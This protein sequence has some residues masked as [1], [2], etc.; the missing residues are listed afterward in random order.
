MCPEPNFNDAART[1]YWRDTH[2]FVSHYRWPVGIGG[3]VLIGLI[4]AGWLMRRN[5][6]LAK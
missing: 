1:R 3:L 4:A 5:V 2:N 6:S